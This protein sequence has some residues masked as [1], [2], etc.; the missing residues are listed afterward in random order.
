MSENQTNTGRKLASEKKKLTAEVEYSEKLV[1]TSEA[2]A[3]LVKAIE[4][5]QDPL[6]G[7]TSNPYTKKIGGTCIIL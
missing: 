3:D 2:C 7:S 4:S 1:K 5:T 6:S